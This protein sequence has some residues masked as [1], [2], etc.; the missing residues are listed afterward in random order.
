MDRLTRELHRTIHGQ[1]QTIDQLA[2]ATGFKAATLYR[3]GLPPETSGLDLPLR[4][5]V[6]IMKA[7]NYY[8]VLKAMADLCGFLLVRPPRAR[9][10]QQDE[11][12]LVHDYQAQCHATVSALLE[13]FKAPNVQLCRAAME[14]LRQTAIASIG[15]EKRLKTHG[16]T[17]LFD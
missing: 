1:K 3:Y 11:D 15:I 12:E 10:N 8:G 7:A 2:Q 5:A 14:T 17:E 4:K 9:R 13:F 6:P 16:Q